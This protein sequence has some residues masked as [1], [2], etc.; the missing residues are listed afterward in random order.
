MADLK[1]IEQAGELIAN[2]GS[3]VAT[4]ADFR[5]VRIT[6]ESIDL[7]GGS[8]DKVE[9]KVSF[10]FGVRALADGAWGFA[11][12]PGC[13]VDAVRM[14]LDEAVAIAKASARLMIKPVALA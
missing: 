9:R 6:T 11:A 2:T 3:R 13:T 14:A 8:V 10:G 5:S 1:Q 12:Y 7:S 4:Y